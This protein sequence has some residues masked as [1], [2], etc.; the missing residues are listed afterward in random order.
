[1]CC[2]KY[3]ISVCCIN[4]LIFGSFLLLLSIG[5]LNDKDNTKIVGNLNLKDTSV[6]LLCI[7]LIL[8]SYSLTNLCRRKIDYT[9]L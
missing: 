5:G 3:N 7:S 1:M 9:P 4:L 2:K 8:I 6:I